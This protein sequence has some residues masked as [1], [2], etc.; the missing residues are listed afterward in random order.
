[1]KFISTLKAERALAQLLAERDMAS[2][3]ARKAIES[4]RKIGPAAIP[5]LIESFA[6]ASKEQLPALVQVLAAQVNE[7]SLKEVVAGL[8]NGNARCI[9]GVA[10]ALAAATDYDPNTLLSYLGREDI[11]VSALIDVLQATRQRLNVRELLRR[12]YDLEP[13]EKA[14][15]FRIINELATEELLPE[16][17]N[18]LEG[19]DPSVRAHI[20]TILSR[21]NTPE[22]GR[23]LEAQL[24]D[25][26]RAI[27]KAALAAIENMPGERN[28]ALLCGLLQDPDLETRSKAIDL[29]IKAAHPDTMRHLVAVLAHESEDARRAAVEVLNGIA[30]AG[31]IKHLLAALEDSDWWVRSRSADALAK[32]GGPKV[33][34]AVLELVR[35]PDD[36]IRR[37]AIEI[38]NLTK[39]ER[40]VE[41]LMRATEDKD[42]WVRERAADALAEIG[43]TRAVPALV[44]MLGGDARSAPAAV[45]ALGRLGDAKIMSTLLPLLD[46]ADKAIRLEAMAAVSRLADH[47]SASTVKA[48]LQP[49]MAGADE[50]IAK[51]AAE[52]VVRLDNRFSTTAVE[53][54][55]RQQRNAS[56]AHTL[57][58]E[59][60]EVERIV[61]EAGGGQT[62]DINQL[63]QGDVIENRYRYIQKIGKGAFGTVV[64]VED[65]VVDERLILKFLNP[66]VSQ[67][68]EMMKRF[69][70]ELRYS[71]KIT[72][73]NVIRI[74]DFVHLSGNYAISMEYFPSHTLGAEISKTRPLPFDK[75]RGWSVDIATGMSVAH[76]VGIVHRDLKPANIL[77]NDEGL[78]KIVDFGVAAVASHAD[79]QLTKTGYVI[80]SPKYMAPEQI[81]G[82]RVDHRADIYSL[83]VIMYEMLTGVP[84]Y[85]KGDHMSVMYQHVQGR[86]K[87]CEE[88]NPQIPPALAAVVRKA[89]EIDK[90]KRFASMDELRAAVQAA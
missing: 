62:L 20:I 59:P 50:T 6:G 64:L 17:L 28:I 30:D 27:R 39:D 8:A 40:S 41:H 7:R 46:H 25:K 13:R 80:G 35:D 31:T 79:T 22:V 21:F 53:A 2:P 45:R 52:A 70:H 16:L 23:A 1:M 24:Q 51:A 12:A 65:T 26:Q 15:V 69:V 19:K 44:K 81:L 10:A 72:H 38:L 89:M 48:R 42:W 61:R 75:A 66:N 49:F 88:I 29:V 56:P 43:S 73:N 37:A 87:P 82:K 58:V 57:L 11:A 54:V 83:G 14:A 5:K 68:E 9:S 74:Y 67:D 90:M 55:E 32:I 77:I 34:D 63:Q 71:R 33:M 3:A 78:L 84:P 36:N 60:A 4:L 47:G 18:R 85:S 76:D 86:C